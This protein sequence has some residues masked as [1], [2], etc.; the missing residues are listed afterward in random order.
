MGSDVSRHIILLC[1]SYWRAYVY[2]SFHSSFGSYYGHY[3]DQN[4][5]ENVSEFGLPEKLLS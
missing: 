3:T 2:K 1:V 4:G 5:G